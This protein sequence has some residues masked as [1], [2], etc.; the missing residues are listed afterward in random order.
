MIRPI[1]R[2]IKLRRFSSLPNLP[3]RSTKELRS[4]PDDQQ[5][6]YLSEIEY[7]GETSKREDRK[8]VGRLGDPGVLE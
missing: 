1:N 7:G 6:D 3:R 5:S 4:E 8:P 2:K